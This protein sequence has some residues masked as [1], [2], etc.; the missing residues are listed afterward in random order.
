MSANNRVR[1]GCVPIPHI[2]LWRT[3]E[4]GDL[5]SHKILI[6]QHFVV[7]KALLIGGRPYTVN[8]I[9]SGR[10]IISIVW[11]YMVL[12]CINNEFIDLYH[13]FELATYWSYLFIGFGYWYCIVSCFELN[14]DEFEMFICLHKLCLLFYFIT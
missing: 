14:C 7:Y 2:N 12:I 4:P 13:Q 6:H 3:W 10:W 1:F 5:N 8:I 9:E 11:F